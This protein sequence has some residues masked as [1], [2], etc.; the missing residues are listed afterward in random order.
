MP[1][2]LRDYRGEGLWKRKANRESG[3]ANMHCARKEKSFSGV[4]LIIPF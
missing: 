4:T 3:Q 2:G 1:A